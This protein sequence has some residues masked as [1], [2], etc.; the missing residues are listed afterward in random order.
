MPAARPETTVIP[1]D[2]S[3]VDASDAQSKLRL[4]AR[5]DP[6]TDIADSPVGLDSLV[7]VI[8]P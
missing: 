8:A 7:Q 5:R 4:E 3:A 2:T 6:T 1:A